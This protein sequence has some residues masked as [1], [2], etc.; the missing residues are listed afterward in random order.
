MVMSFDYV[1]AACSDL[2]KIY[3][4]HTGS[5]QVSHSLSNC[6]LP[7]P[8]HTGRGLL[9]AN[10]LEGT[11]FDTLRT[12]ALCLALCMLDGGCFDG[13]GPAHVWCSHVTRAHL[14]CPLAV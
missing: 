3:H 12:L 13:S 9:L 14:P 8:A 10:K 5:I 4:I 7:A 11:T 1:R 2:R 6:K